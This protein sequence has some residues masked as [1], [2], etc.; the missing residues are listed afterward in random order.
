MKFKAKL[1]YVSSAA[2][3]NRKERQTFIM[4]FRIYIDVKCEEKTQH[5]I[6][7]MLAN[8]MLTF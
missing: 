3:C 1:S 5:F 6:I 7:E 2:S 4:Q 8:N